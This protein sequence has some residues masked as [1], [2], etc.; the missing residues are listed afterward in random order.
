MGLHHL[1]QEWIHIFRVR[2]GWEQLWSD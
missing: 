2:V 1:Q